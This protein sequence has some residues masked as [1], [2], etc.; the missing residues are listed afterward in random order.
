MD[1][2][3]GGAETRHVVADRGDAGQRLDLVLLRRLADVPGLS[4]TRVQRSI[5]EGRVRVGGRRPS[6][7]SARVALG[8]EIRV[9]LPPARPRGVPRGEPADVVVLHEDG[10][11]I[12]VDK[13]AGLVAHPAYKHARGTLL[14]ALLW[15]GEHDTPP[16]TPRLVHRLDRH[17]S[18]VLLAAKTDEAYRF[19][20]TA[21]R[22]PDVQKTYLAIVWGRPPRRR[23]EIRLR[24]DRDPVDTRRVLASEVRGRESLTRY[25]LVA[26]SRGIR[27]GL[28]LLAC[29]LVTGRLHQIRAHLAA[30]GLPIV[31]DPV[32]GPTRLPP[33]VD[34]RLAALAKALPRQAL[35]AWRLRVPH[36][37]G[38]TT[39]DVSAPLPGDMHELLGVAGIDADEAL[40]RAG[41]AARR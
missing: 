41:L 40:G 9:D 14:N 30:I 6:K 36:P 19:M 37:G 23:G 13:P 3:R 26:A 38:T 10:A 12:V 18:G 29:R 28:S 1:E 20:S 21:W 16:W 25:E 32:Y 15:R 4:R 7:A 33:S 35:H 39:I 34:T 5:E 17:T 31:G 22:T 2:T 11:L 24:L 8:D 27:A